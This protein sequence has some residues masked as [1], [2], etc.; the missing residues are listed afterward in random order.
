MLEKINETTEFLKTKGI[1][2]PD[3]G[4]FLVQDLGDY[5]KN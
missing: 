4:L 1:N 2:N 3:A 5:L